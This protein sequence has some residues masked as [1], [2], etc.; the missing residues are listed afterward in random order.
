[1]FDQYGV[2]YPEAGWTW[3]D[4]LDAAVA[5]RDSKAGIYGFG[6]NPDNWDYVG[7]IY[8]QGG[9]LF[10]DLQEPTRTMF[11][12]PENIAAMEWYVDLSEKHNVAPTREQVQTEFRG[13]VYDG[14]TRG[15]VGMMIGGL[16]WRQEYNSDWG[17]ELGMVPLPREEGT[18]TLGWWEEGLFISS[19]AQNPD[20]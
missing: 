10:D 15:K 7:V 3:D 9:Q 14:I 20:A 12:D 11:D 18:P 19:E 4:F 5:L 16:S 2:P 17:F 13:F 6:A 8:P 1:M